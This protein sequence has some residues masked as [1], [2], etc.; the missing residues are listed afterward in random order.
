[1]K[2]LREKIRKIK[3]KLKFFANKKKAKFTY[4][5]NSKSNQILTDLMNLHG[6]DKGGKNNHHNYS[7]YYSELFYNNKNNIKNFLEI[8]LGSNNTNIPSN[9]GS[10]G[11]PLA[12]LRAW[13][14]FFKN[15]NIFGAD[16]D[17]NI[18][19]NED[20]I[21]TF[22]VDQTDPK[23]IKEMFEKIGIKKFDIILEDGLHEFNAN[24]CFFENSINFLE[25]DGTYIIEDVYYKDQDRFMN[26][27]EKTNFNFSIVDIFHEKNIANNCLIIIRKN[28]AK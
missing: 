7:D 24:L 16:I 3:Y 4:L 21:K 10:D 5:S 8:G 23:S 22:Y 13:K 28:N 25:D 9:M 6:S 14:D 17:K 20:R 27:F 12:S 1:M 26:Y 18:L 15:A 11:I 2:L 19:K